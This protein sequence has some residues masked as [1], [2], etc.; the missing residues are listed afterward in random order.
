MGAKSRSEL[1][2]EALLKC[3]N[4]SPRTRAVSWLNDWLRSAYSSWEWPFLMA[5]KSG[6]AV[7][8]SSRVNSV[9]NNLNGITQEIRRIYSP[10]FLYLN[11]PVA[12][13]AVPITQLLGNDDPLLDDG[14]NEGTTG[15]PTTCRIRQTSAPTG[16]V[17]Q[18]DIIFDRIPDRAY[19]MSFQCSLL[20]PASVT[21]TD[22]PLYPNDRTM[23][24]AIQ[25]ECYE[26][27]R[28]KTMSDACRELLAAQFSEDKHKFGTQSGHHD[29]VQLDKSVFR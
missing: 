5:R 13:F 14:V 22:V 4:T 21:M 23:I 2:T 24:T 19:L 29:M 6:I 12:R 18:W 9:G 11:S 3:G 16:L 26:Y 7:S 20:P 28:E 15:R 1:I 17:G 25:A 8:T 10:L 27:M